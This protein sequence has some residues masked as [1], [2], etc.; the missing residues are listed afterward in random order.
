MVVVILSGRNLW[1]CVSKMN[2]DH[3]RELENWGI[4]M[5]QQGLFQSSQRY[6]TFNVIGLTLRRRG[7]LYH[8]LFALQL[9]QVWDQTVRASSAKNLLC[10]S[11][12]YSTL[13]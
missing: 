10:R 1:I 9:L 5:S 11:T 7:L 13:Y 2:G 12:T 4:R 8:R 6:R 3:S